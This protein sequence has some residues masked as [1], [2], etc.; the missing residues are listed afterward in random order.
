MQLLTIGNPK[1]LKGEKFNYHTAILHLSPFTSANI[2][3][4]SGNLLNVC[5]YAVNCTDI[6]L[7][8]SG[9]G[10]I[11]D[12]EVNRIQIARRSRTE[13]FHNKKRDFFDQLKREL[14]K[15][16]E[17]S[18]QLGMSFAFR[19]NGT[20]DLPV[21]GAWAARKFPKMQVYD[22]TKIPN[23]WKR[24]QRFDNYHLTFSYDGSNW[25]ECQKSLDKGINV[26]VVFKS[27]LP[28]E[29][30]GYPVLD[31]DESDLRF[32]DQFP[33]IVGLRAK[34][35]AKKNGGIFTTEN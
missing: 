33:A 10:G 27:D 35:P 28:A 31:G 14:L 16:I 12:P 15:E 29:F 6:C 22:Y 11:G 20:S 30:R 2:K 1:T 9:R 4:R 23:P 32:L 5:P 24:A 17:K 26:A 21:I 25:E 34:G 13:M 18:E 3:T 8:Y 7:N 19:P